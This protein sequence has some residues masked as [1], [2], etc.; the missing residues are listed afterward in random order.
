MAIE[1]ICYGKHL[2]I[3]LEC[4]EECEE[5]SGLSRT[6]CVSCRDDRVLLN[7]ECVD[8]C[9]SGFYQEGGV[10]QKCITFPMY[11][12]LICLLYTSPSPRDSCASR[13]PSSACKKKK[14]KNTKK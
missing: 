14:Q 13:M 2:E 11:S 7:G 10:C 4:H 8:Q 12:A 9:P 1:G 5:C 6:G 3:I